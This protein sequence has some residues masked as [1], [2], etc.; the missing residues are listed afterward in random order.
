[1]Q[2]QWTHIDARDKGDVKLQKY[3]LSIG[4]KREGVYIM[5]AFGA[6]RVSSAEKSQVARVAQW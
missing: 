1:M 5:H 3:N 4:A 6:E 2:G